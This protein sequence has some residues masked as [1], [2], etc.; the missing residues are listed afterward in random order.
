[1][2]ILEKLNFKI[3]R[4]SMHPDTP[5][6][7]RSYFCLAN[8]ELLPPGMLLPTVNTNSQYLNYTKTFFFSLD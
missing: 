8:S 7:A 1:M 5:G 4:E 3:S 2:Y 6:S